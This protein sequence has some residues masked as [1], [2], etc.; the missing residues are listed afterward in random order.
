MS[1]DDVACSATEFVFI[2]GLRRR[3]VSVDNFVY[4]K[5]ESAEEVVQRVWAYL[6]FDCSSVTYEELLKLV[7]NALVQH[8]EYRRE[9]QKRLENE[10]IQKDEEDKR[11]PPFRVGKRD[12]D[13]L[14]TRGANLRD[15]G[16]NPEA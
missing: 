2:P 9:R 12:R 13:I 3:G 6:D 15:G 16:Y 11:Y 10:G 5:G 7:R 8:E 1:S 4:F 14:V